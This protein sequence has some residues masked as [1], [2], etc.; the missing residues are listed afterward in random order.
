M[1]PDSPV[2]NR[3][4]GGFK[5]PRAARCPSPDWWLDVPASPTWAS[6]SYLKPVFQSFSFSAFALIPCS[7]SEDKTG[8]EE[9]KGSDHRRPMTRQFEELDFR[10]TPLGELSLRRKK[11]RMLDDEIVY[12]VK[13]D[14]GFLMSSLFT[15]VE[16]ATAE[17]GLAELAGES[18]LDVVVGGLGLGYTALAALEN[19]AVQSLL[20]VEFLDPVIEWHKQGL[21]PLGERLTGDTRCRFVR[22]DFF[23]CS[24]NPEVG[25]DPTQPGR[26]FHAILLDIDHTPNLLLHERHGPFYRPEGLRNLAAHLHPGGVFSMW[27]DGGVDPNFLEALQSVFPRAEARRVTFHNPLQDRESSSTVYIARKAAGAY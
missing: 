10:K 4:S 9:A 22:G 15:A 2:I 1:A 3:R 27:S 6:L 26:R 24:A 25:F 18:G 8:P 20:V 14:E 19:P 5:P 11:V 12:E 21:V 13:L 7:M 23:A 16:R 17:L